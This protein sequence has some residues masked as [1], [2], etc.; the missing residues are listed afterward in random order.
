MD[1][2]DDGHKPSARSPDVRMHANMYAYLFLG[3]FSLVIRL[4]TINMRLSIASLLEPFM[5]KV[6]KVESYV[7][8]V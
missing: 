2:S 8:I 7:N 3:P 4:E 5:L 1:R 6:N